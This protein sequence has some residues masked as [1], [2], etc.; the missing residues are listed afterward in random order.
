MFSF[1][2][3][4]A[5]TLEPIKHLQKDSANNKPNWHS[6]EEAYGTIGFLS[7]FTALVNT[8]VAGLI[9]WYVLKDLVADYRD[10][11][12]IWLSFWHFNFLSL[13]DYFS[14]DTQLHYVA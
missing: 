10:A 6:F 2:M 3:G 13:S 8:M 11:Q 12:S 14:I 9:G 1:A 4:G 7:I 5:K